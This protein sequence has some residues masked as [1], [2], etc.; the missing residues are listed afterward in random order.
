MMKMIIMC[1]GVAMLTGCVSTELAVKNAT[2]EKVTVI[3]GHTG[4]SYGIGPGKTTTVPHTV[5][6]LSVITETG[7]KW[8]Y[9]AVSALDGRTEHCFIFWNKIVKPFEIKEQDIPNKTSE[10]NVVPAPQIQ[11]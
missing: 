4:R 7:K 11:R 5:G 2:P 8:E 3:S 1:F 9:P 6:S 10:P